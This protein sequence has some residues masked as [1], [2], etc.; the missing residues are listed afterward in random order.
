MLQCG[1]DGGGETALAYPWLA[2]IGCS[3]RSPTDFSRI[4]P[5]VVRDLSRPGA[6]TVQLAAA[7]SE[8]R[9]AG[10]MI[11]WRAAE[12][13]VVYDLSV[14]REILRL[15]LSALGGRSVHAWD[16]Q[17]DGKLAVA[18]SA[19]PDAPDATKI[20]WAA[21]N[22]PQPKV[23]SADK[24][25]RGLRLVGGR[26]A[27]ERG[28][29][30]SELVVR[31]LQGV[32]QVVARYPDEV[33]GFDFDGKRVAWARSGCSTTEIAVRAADEPGTD[34]HRFAVCPLTFD[35]GGSV[36]RRGR[37]NARAHCPTLSPRRPGDSCRVVATLRLDGRRIATARR[38]LRAGTSG[39]LRFS[40]RPLLLRR[41]PARLAVSAANRMR[42]GTLVRRATINPDYPDRPRR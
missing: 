37:L 34:D 21:P 1:E 3:A 28:R 32:E 17:A 23:I 39:T 5:V 31:A 10:R 2:Y 7:G 33:G 9:A 11:A 13:F 24:P 29:N 16:V 22:D 15:A 27:F 20:V 41:R 40:A 8:V 6:A 38:R 12:A 14:G 30:P 26:L 18:T 35:R 42:G 19:T 4:S 36:D 25:F